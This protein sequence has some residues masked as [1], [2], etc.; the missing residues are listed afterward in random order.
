M[1]G[2][3]RCKVCRALSRDGLKCEHCGNRKSVIGSL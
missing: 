2:W 1:S 3:F